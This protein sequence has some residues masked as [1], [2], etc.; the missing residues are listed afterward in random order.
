M[1]YVFE[2]DQAKNLSN[3]QKHDGISFEEATKVFDDPLC[4]SIQDRIENGEQRSQTFGEVG[5]LVLLMVAHTLWEEDED[6]E[7]TEIVRIISAR[8]ATRKERLWYEDE[9]R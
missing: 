4:I 8:K 3:Q 5:G 1:S 6:G 2:W 9:H 7:Q